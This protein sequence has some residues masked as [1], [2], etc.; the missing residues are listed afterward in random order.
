MSATQSLLKA[1]VA[2][3]DSSAGDAIRTA[4]CTALY[5]GRAP[6][7]ASYPFGVLSVPASVAEPTIGQGTTGA[8]RYNSIDV[9][10]SFFTDQRSPNSLF[11]IS[12]AWHAAFDFADMS[13]ESP[14]KLVVGHKLDDGIP[15]EEP[16][17]KGFQLSFVYGYNVAE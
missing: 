11:G 6:Q 9:Q 13:L 7:S 12:G 17:Q 14:Y 16:Q 15:I 4:G 8:G 10:V 2:R 1:I 3:Y 5:F